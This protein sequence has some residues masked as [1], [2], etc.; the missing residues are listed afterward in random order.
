MN[1]CPRD[2]PRYWR[3]LSGCS[4]GTSAKTSA[5]PSGSRATISKRP[6]GFTSGSSSIRY[7]PPRQ[8]FP[9]GVEVAHLEEGANSV[10]GR[11]GR[12][13]RD[14]EEAA[15]EK[16]DDAAGFSVAPLAVDGEAKRVLVE[17]ERALEV[18]GT[19]EDAARQDLH[20]AS[21]APGALTHSSLG[22]TSGPQPGPPRRRLEIQKSVRDP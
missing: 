22:G 20:P 19:K 4:G 21:L 5:R 18:L 13:A 11:L 2:R 10:G 12:G 14:L 1:R 6:H 9:D 15:A 8:P 16:E 7:A 3:R 17:A